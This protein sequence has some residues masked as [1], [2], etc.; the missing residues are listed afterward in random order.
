MACRNCGSDT[1]TAKLGDWRLAAPGGSG[2]A[3]VVLSGGQDSTTCLF[4]A[5]ERFDKVQ[6]VTF[7]YGQRHSREILAAG[8]VAQ[9]AGVYHEIVDLGPILRGTSPLTDHTRPVG[10]YAD[11]ESLPGGLE[12]TFVPGRNILFLTLAGNYAYCAGATHIVMG[13]CEEDF[14]GYPD[15]RAGF[16]SAMQTALRLGLG[17][18]M[19]PRGMLTV[20]TPLMNLTK[21]ESVVLAAQLPGCLD[22][23]AWSHTCYRGEE[24]PCGRCHACLLRAR[25]FEEA[26]IA[27]PLIARHLH[28]GT[29][30]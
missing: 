23:L 12:D 3:L 26:G 13:V 15:C 27:D 20:E 19:D 22:A 29:A 8:T 2:H 7:N 17:A 9:I 30:R 25:G 14:G 28:G 24:P 1:V 16:V 18:D 6:A 10:L 21:A 4:W 5:L 11:A